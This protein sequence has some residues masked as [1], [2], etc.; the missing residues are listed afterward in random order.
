V[1]EVVLERLCKVYPNGV[2]AVDD[3]NLTVADG[4]Y[5]VL[6]G[7]SGCGKTTTLRLIAGLEEATSGTI[8]L[9]SRPVTALPPHQ[10]NVALIAQRPALF[11]HLNTEQNLSLRKALRRPSWWTLLLGRVFRGRWVRQRLDEDRLLEERSEELLGMLGLGPLRGRYPDQLS[12]GQ[13]QRVALGRALLGRP[14]VFLLDEPLSNLDVSLRSEMLGE[15]HLLRRRFPA[16]II[17]VTHDPLEA[18]SLGDRLVVLNQGRIQQV[19][20]PSTLHERPAN[21]FVA[22]LVGWP[23]MNLLPGRLVERESQFFLECPGSENGLVHLPVPPSKGS[24]WRGVVGRAIL[25]GIRPEAVSTGSAGEQPRAGSLVLQVE[26]IEPQPGRALVTWRLGE[27]RLVGQVG[28]PTTIREGQA[29][30]VTLNLD[31]SYLFD[32]AT[33]TALESTG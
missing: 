2:R 4:E 22:E 20:K 11:P 3:L 31:K 26:R 29:T 25:L 23:P 8:R 1:A 33:G 16:T 30:M 10:R 6:I 18:M 28:W 21:R 19:G 14:A 12:G 17:H 32:Q 7:P 15:L 27:R 9:G 24:L 13:Q 5:V